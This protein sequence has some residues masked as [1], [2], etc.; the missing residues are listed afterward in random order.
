MNIK[1]SRIENVKKNVEMLKDAIKLSDEMFVKVFGLPKEKGVENI[2]N[3]ILIDLD[4][5]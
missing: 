5:E 3:A 2:L 1:K 4:V